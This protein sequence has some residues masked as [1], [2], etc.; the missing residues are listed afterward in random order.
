M[1][2]DVLMR[3]ALYAVAMLVA[4]LLLLQLLIRSFLVF[5]P[6]ERYGVVERKWAFRG[7]EQGGGF[8]SRTG[9]PGFVPEVIRGVWKPMAARNWRCAR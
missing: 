3:N 5:I 8:M 2:N 7:A 6:N 4:A 9:A 1:P